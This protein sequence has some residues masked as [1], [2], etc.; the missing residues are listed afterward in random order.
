MTNSKISNAPT[1]LSIMPV[2]CLVLICAFCGCA[3]DRSGAGRDNWISMFN[4]KTGH[5]MAGFMESSRT[6]FSLIYV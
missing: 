2:L 5:G 1:R 4:V 6:L 3:M